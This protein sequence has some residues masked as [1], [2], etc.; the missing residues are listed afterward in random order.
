[1][2]KEELIQ[3]HNLLSDFESLLEFNKIS[4]KDVKSLMQSI[5]EI[6]AEIEKT[7]RTFSS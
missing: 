6:Q 1:M 7:V 5:Y 4:G 2:S 3:L